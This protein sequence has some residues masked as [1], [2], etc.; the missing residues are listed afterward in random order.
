M[1]TYLRP[2]YLLTLEFYINM[3]AHALS[4]RSPEFGESQR[5]TGGIMTNLNLLLP[6][7]KNTCSCDIII[8]SIIIMYT[9][10]DIAPFL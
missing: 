8:A 7:F 10:A 3:L 4:S 9:F 6:L 5:R 1:I 2:S